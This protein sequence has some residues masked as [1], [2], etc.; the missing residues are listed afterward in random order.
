MTTT[1]VTAINDIII[2]AGSD[3]QATVSTGSVLVLAVLRAQLQRRGMLRYQYLDHDGR[4]QLQ[5]TPW[6]FIAEYSFVHYPTQVSGRDI[7][8]EM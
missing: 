4:N 7:S 1:A 5:D 6:S 3:D 2:G 8:C